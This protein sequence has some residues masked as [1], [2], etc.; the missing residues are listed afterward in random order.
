MVPPV[1]YGTTNSSKIHATDF[2]S[3][4]RDQQLAFLIN[5]YNALTVKLI[6]KHYPVASIK[7]IGNFFRSSW[8]IDF[9]N[10]LGEERNLDDIEH[11]MIR[12]QSRFSEPRIH[13]ALVCASKGCPKLQ[14][15]AFTAENLEMLLQQGARE[16]LTDRS[17][18]RY[19]ADNKTLSLSMIFKW[20]G[21]DFRDRHGSVER[22][23]AEYITDPALSQAIGTAQK[24]SIEYLDYDWSLND[25][26]SP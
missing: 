2:E 22:F 5:A 24:I 19:N 6:V 20:Y 7:D 11:N 8:K 25:I 26:D 13:F 10:L 3:W 17:R 16:F 23:V 21:D 14:P 9:F 18:N 15:T 1:G 12:G 4:T